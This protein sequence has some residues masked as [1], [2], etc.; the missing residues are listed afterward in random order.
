MFQQLDELSDL[1]SDVWDYCNW[2]WLRDARSPDQCV[3]ITLDEL[4]AMRGILKKLNG[5]RQRGGYKRGQKAKVLKSVVHL[6]NVLI[7][8]FDFELRG[9]GLRSGRSAGEPIRDRAIRLEDGGQ[10]DFDGDI[11]NVTSFGFRP[12]NIFARYVFGPGRQTA[13]LSAKALEYDPRTQKYEKR[14]IRFLSW[15]WRIR[16]STL[17][18]F[19]PF[20]VSTLLEKIH[21][22]VNGRFP[23]RTVERLERALE[24]IAT[25]GSITQWQ[26][27]SGQPDQ[28]RRGWSNVWLQETILI[29]PPQG[30]IDQYQNIGAKRTKADLFDIGEF[31]GLADL[32][33]RKRARADLSVLRAAEQSGVAPGDYLK[34]EQGKKQPISVRAQLERWLDEPDASKATG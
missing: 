11:P 22:P 28:S 10:T 3:T 5:Q 2:R 32:L 16:A 18:Y 34:A 14:L 15:I 30:I 24:T 33:K 13:L 7:N 31:C 23:T 29:E 12:G 17:S 9:R 19:Q 8:L 20:R 6:R 4:L 1:D 26:Y 27:E 25:D 21:L